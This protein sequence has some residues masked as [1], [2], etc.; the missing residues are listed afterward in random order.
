MSS[1][2]LTPAPPCG[3]VMESPPLSFCPS[4]A[5]A[6]A[7]VLAGSAARSTAKRNDAQL[8]INLPELGAAVAAAERQPSP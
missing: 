6:T 8:P 7:S 1:T 3:W 2:G 4:T 5:G